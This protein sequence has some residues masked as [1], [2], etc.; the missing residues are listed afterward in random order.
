MAVFYANGTTGSPEYWTYRLRLLEK[1]QR[2][3]KTLL[4]ASAQI[5]RLRVGSYVENYTGS[6]SITVNGEVKSSGAFHYNLTVPLGTWVTLW[7]AEF[8][9]PHSADGSKTVSVSSLWENGAFS[10]S[11]A[12]VQSTSVAL[13]PIPVTPPPPGAP[14]VLTAQG[15]EGSSDCWFGDEITLAWSAA[16]GTVDSYEVQYAVSEPNTASFGEWKPWRSGLS[17]TSLTDSASRPAGS[18]IKYRVR[19]VNAFSEGE[20]KES[21][22]LTV[23]GGVRLKVSGEWRTGSVWVKAGGVWRRAKSLWQKSTVWR[24]SR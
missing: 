7:T 16:S 24:R 15:G 6:V 20:W 11:S 14:A 3:N 2:N 17:Q 8:E 13:T 5:G 9:V 4:Q 19:A 23:R 1:A 10:P 18:R 21:N 12:S 22:I